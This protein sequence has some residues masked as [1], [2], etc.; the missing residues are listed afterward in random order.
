MRSASSSRAANGSVSVKQL[1]PYDVQLARLDAANPFGVALYE[2]TLHVRRSSRTTPPPS[3]TQCEL[4]GRGLAPARPTFASTTVDPSKRSS[5]SSRS[6][7]VRQHLLDAQ[8]PLLVPRRGRPSASFHTGSCTAR[9]RASLRQGDAEHLE[10]DALHVV[11][12]LLL[13]ESERVD[14]H[15]VPEAA[16]LLVGDAVALRGRCG[17]RSRVNARI[18]HISS[19][20][21]MPGVDEERDAADDLGQLFR[22]HLAGVADGVEHARSRSRART[23][24]PARVSRPL[25]ARWYGHTLI[26]FHFGTCLHGVGR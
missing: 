17:P 6:D 4:G 26:G 7:L 11:L 16:Q 18:L 5:Y 2:A 22:G 24:A 9:A 12:G 8:R 25:P 20:K 3:R 13:G 1:T 19:T 10:H 14:L 21:R 15:P 23:R